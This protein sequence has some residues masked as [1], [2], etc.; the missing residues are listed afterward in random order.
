IEKYIGNNI[1]SIKND[2]YNESLVLNNKYNSQYIIK[3]IINLCFSILFIILS[4]K[5]ISLN[6]MKLSSLLIINTF[7]NLFL[8][9]LVNILDLEQDYQEA[10]SSY[11]RLKEIYTEEKEDDDGISIECIN[12]IKFVNTS[13]SY[14]GKN[15]VVNNINLNI[16]KGDKILVTGH[17]GSG[18]ST[19]FKL[20]NKQLSN[21]KIYIN[22][23]KIDKIS[24]SCIRK[25]ITY[26]DQNERLFTESINNNL[27]LNNKLDQNVVDIL[28]INNIINKSNVF[29]DAS[30][31]SGG[32]KSKIIIG[33]AIMCNND[34][35]I[36]D[37]TTSQ[38]DANGE[39]EILKSIFNYYP[40][41]IF[42]II[43]HRLVNKDIFDKVVYF[44]NGRIKEVI[45][46]A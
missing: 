19:L 33:R 30:N 3:S 38:I 18:K 37:E 24:S 22:D 46:S 45:N 20:L 16:N 34:M 15:K 21:S 10:Y 23:I 11:K 8:D 2:M 13:Y 40:N 9:L 41:K 43:S 4:I 44:E 17:S 29:Q 1:N 25:L 26:I 12:N 32:E 31:L 42:I 5:L 28:D 14:N 36:F 7:V 6:I 27:V 39:K 35:V